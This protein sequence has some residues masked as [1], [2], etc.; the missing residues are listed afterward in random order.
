M[1]VKKM[2]EAAMLT[3]LSVILTRLV[4][5]GFVVALFGMSPLTVR[6]AL[7]LIPIY[8][9]S[10]LL[11]PVWGAS[12]AAAADLIGYFIN[13]LGGAYFVGF[14]ITA[15]LCGAIPGLVTKLFGDKFGG[16]TAAVYAASLLSCVLNT[17]L[18]V[19]LYE[20]PFFILFWPRLISS[21][22]MSVIYVFAVYF[23]LGLL[24]RLE[25]HPS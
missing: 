6:L 9:A 22:I 20:T 17:F 23:L 13:P 16:I 21:V 24:K 4:P 1:S 14:T 25:K 7:G 12:V 5:T 15:A 18:L 3:A 19:Y 8:I 11:G 2:C 10:I